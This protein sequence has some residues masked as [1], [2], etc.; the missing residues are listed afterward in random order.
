M[1]DILS[2]LIIRTSLPPADGSDPG[3]NTPTRRNSANTIRDPRPERRGVEARACV[4]DR[5]WGLCKADVMGRDEADS[6]QEGCAAGG[7]GLTLPSLATAS[8]STSRAPWMN[9]VMTTGCSCGGGGAEHRLGH[10][11]KH[12]G[13]RARLRF[14]RDP[15][16]TYISSGS[17]A[18]LKKKKTTIC[19]GIEST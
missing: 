12:W 7:G 6:A 2:T 8:T 1:E 9:L 19:R 3:S 14:I 17:A 15:V 11:H 18:R 10:A 5:G 16:G 4:C 13:G